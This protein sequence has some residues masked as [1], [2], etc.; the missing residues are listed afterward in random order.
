MINSRTNLRTE[1]LRRRFRDDER[2][3]P[4]PTTPLNH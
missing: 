3:A 4:C 1:M 2:V